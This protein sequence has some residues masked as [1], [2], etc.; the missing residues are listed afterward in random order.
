MAKETGNA[1][2]VKSGQAPDFNFPLSHTLTH[3]LLPAM[4]HALTPEVLSLA[5]LLSLENSPGG[6]GCPAS[7]AK[8]RAGTPSGPVMTELS[9]SFPDAEG[10]VGRD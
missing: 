4:Y 7:P 10:R 1:L 9:V 5:V 8:D 2:H 3:C 6:R